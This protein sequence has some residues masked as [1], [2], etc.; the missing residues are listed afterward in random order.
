METGER[1]NLREIEAA[2][3]RFK[4]CPKCI[5]TEGFWLGLKG[6]HAYAQCKG[7]GARFE[8]FEVYKISEKS[9]APKWLKFLKK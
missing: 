8:L 9:E 1:L 5:S 3:S 2:F 7:C 4:I 6:D